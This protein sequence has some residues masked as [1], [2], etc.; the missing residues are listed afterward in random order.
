MNKTSRSKL[1]GLMLSVAVI[2]VLLG[3]SV[4]PALTPAAVPAFPAS[5]L[6]TAPATLTTTP[7]TLGSTIKIPGW[8]ELTL[9]VPKQNLNDARLTQL[10]S[11]GWKY[12]G[13]QPL[14]LEDGSW[15]PPQ[16]LFTLVTSNVWTDT[17]MNYSSWKIG[18]PALEVANQTTY[19][20]YITVHTSLAVGT[21][22]YTSTSLA[23][24]V[25]ASGLGRA[26]GTWASAAAASGDK[27]WN[28][29]KSFS[30]SGTVSGIN[31]T[32]LWTNS[33]AGRGVLLA[34]GQFVPTS[35]V[36]GDTLQI[37]HSSAMTN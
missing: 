7:T 21:C 13:L 12:Q 11:D 3:M 25:A 29:T 30:A 17:G 31:A 16:A 28:Q 10:T 15:L 36:A 20:R 34:C 22:A 4:A 8:F 5:V 33:G 9:S 14:K 19:A 35:V 27:T 37:R 23:S 1:F 2:S 18:N 32:G 24:E 26:E 6:S